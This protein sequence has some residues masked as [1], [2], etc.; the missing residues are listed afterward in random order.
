M[1][2]VEVKIRTSHEPIR[3]EVSELNGTPIGTVEQID[4]Y[5]DA[6]HRDF[7]AT[8]E[9]LR[10]R[11]ERPEDGTPTHVLT[12]K[13]PLIDADSKTREEIEVSIPEPE[14]FR[15]ILEALGFSPAATVRKKRDRYGL[16]ECIVSL[17]TV[18]GLGE[19]VEVEAEGP[20][21]T[22]EE[23]RERAFDVLRALGLDP[24]EQLRTS[25]LGLLLES[26]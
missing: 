25:Y 21:E 22:I 14:E 8:D 26:P 4:T 2:E 18:D 11:Q 17:D 1:Y 5:F 23:P 13:G 7:A 12:Y 15:A 10:L 20:A 9:A 24:A 19:F 3:E 16:D 6:P